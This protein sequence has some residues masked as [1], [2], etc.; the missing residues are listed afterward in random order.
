MNW[1]GSGLSKQNFA[2]KEYT[3]QYQAEIE[4]LEAVEDELRDKVSLLETEN[5]LLKESLAN[6]IITTLEG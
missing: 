6:P 2:I 5:L 4:R 1:I 3:T